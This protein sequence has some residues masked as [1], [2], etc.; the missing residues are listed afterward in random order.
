MK[1]TPT[2]AA[3]SKPII[4]L[5]KLYIAFYFGKPLIAIRFH[6]G[7]ALFNPDEPV[8]VASNSLCRLARFVF[9]R[10][11]GEQRVIDLGDHGRHAED[12]GL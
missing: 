9:R 10:T 4:Q 8:L 6:S 5:K 11:G 3:R 7:Q 1:N 2:V 12:F